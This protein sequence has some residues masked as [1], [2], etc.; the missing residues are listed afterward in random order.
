ELLSEVASPSL[1][2]GFG[3]ALKRVRW[4]FAIEAGHGTAS[5]AVVR[6]GTRPSLEISEK[7]GN[8]L[9]LKWSDPDPPTYLPVNDLRFYRP[10]QSTIRSDVVRDVNRRLARGVGCTLMLG[11]ARPWKAG[12]DAVERHWLQL[13]G[14]VLDDRPVGDR[15]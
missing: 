10:D 15:P 13:N 6:A 5:L 9:Q 12:G 1:E 14:L 3:P 4:K 2:D 8:R 7:Y 11:V